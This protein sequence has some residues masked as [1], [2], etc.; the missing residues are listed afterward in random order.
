MS[1]FDGYMLRQLLVFFGFFLLVLVG[2]LWITRSVSLFDKLIGGGQSAMVFLEF[3]ALSL[4]TLIRTVM[5]MAAF[6][7]AVYATNR[8]SRDSEMTVMLATGASPLRLARP[9][10]YFG[11]VTA[12]MMAGLTTYLRPAS[13]QKLGVREA[14]VTRDLTAQLLNE[15]SFM[16]PAQG[17]TFYIGRIDEDGTLNDVFLSD[18]RNPDQPITYTGAR[19]F[20]V[21]DDARVSL[22]MVQGMAMRY[23]AATNALSTTLFQDFSYDITSLATTREN[24][25]RNLRGVPTTELMRTDTRAA[26]EADHGYSQGQITEELHERIAWVLICIA[27]PLLGYATL[28]MGGFSRFGLWPQLLTAFALLLVMEGLRGAATSVVVNQPH[29]WWLLYAP[30]ALGLLLTSI[31]LRA[32]GRPLR[33]FLSRSRAA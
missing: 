21:R 30:A 32:A 3:T 16:H 5:P 19:A 33:L 18:R 28:M 12:L 29:Y 26:L 27:V 2:V 23:E 7:A 31:F 22:V 25:R 4:P 9:V 24:G 1:R 6:G 8:L 11:M 20:L 17:V 10:L 13:I 14:E 15:G